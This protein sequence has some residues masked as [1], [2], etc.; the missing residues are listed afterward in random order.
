[1]DPR[2]DKTEIFANEIAE[3]DTRAKKIVNEN[4]VESPNAAVGACPTAE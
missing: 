1:M 3:A 2:A 4:L